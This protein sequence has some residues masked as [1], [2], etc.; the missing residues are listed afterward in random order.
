METTYDIAVIGGGIV[1]LATANA[2]L[3]ASPNR[4]LILLEAEPKLAAHQTGHNSGVIHSGL[5]YKPGSMKARFCVEGREAMYDFCRAHDIPHERCGKVVVATT[6]N[7]IPRLEELHRRG[8]ANGLKG[9]R[10]L[11][12]E[13]IR[14]REPYASGL[15]GLFVPDTGIVDYKAV[16][17]TLGRMAQERGC[18]VKIASRLVGFH[19]KDGHI[20]LQ[21]EAYEVRCR[22][23]VNCGGL[24]SDRVARLCGVNPGVR[25]VPFRGEYYELIQSREFLVRNLIYPV[26]DPGFP[27]LGVHFTRM[28][29]GGIEA[30]PNAVLAFK[31]EGYRKTDF[32]A[33]DLADTLSYWGFWRMAGRCWKTGMG[34]VWRS[35]NKRAFV[36]ALQRLIPDLKQDDVV[37]AGSGVRAQAMDPSGNLLDDFHVIRAESMIHVLNAPSPAATS[38]LRI[39]KAI[40]SMA[41]DHLN[42]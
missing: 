4:R 38:S 25:I 17:Q 21:T 13:E 28:I 30:G 10:W 5:Y 19:R 26:P 8:E 39:G 29:G 24:Q 31:R 32:A 6:A 41:S 36:T 40:A 15:R 2:L 22:A 7:E 16:A 23:L 35:L 18:D 42:C 11:T 37:R 27:F 12:A 9:I 1:G 20:L 34:E 3:D 33:R 14:E